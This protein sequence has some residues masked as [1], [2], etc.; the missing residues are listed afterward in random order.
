MQP[1]A[2]F[3]QHST[4]IYNP[5][6]TSASSCTSIIASLPTKV[7]GLQS[8]T[9]EAPHLSSIPKLLDSSKEPYGVKVSSNT[10][11]VLKVSW[12]MSPIPRDPTS[13]PRSP[14]RLLWA[15]GF[16][17]PRRGSA[18]LPPSRA[19]YNLTFHINQRCCANSETAQHQPSAAS[20]SGGLSLPSQRSPARDGQQIPSS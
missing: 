9:R 3:P 4:A 13:L 11:L 2:I 19:I 14:I 12:M 18:I 5:S 15:I 6:R 16:T 8:K 10:E 17:P 1:P 20:L 7:L